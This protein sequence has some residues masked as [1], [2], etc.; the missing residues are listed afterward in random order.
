[1][2]RW[3]L[4]EAAAADSGSGDKNERS[5]TRTSGCPERAYSCFPPGPP[6]QLRSRPGSL[7]PAAARSRLSEPHSPQPRL[8]AQHGQMV[9]TRTLRTF[10]PGDLL[11]QLRY[12]IGDPG[13]TELRGGSVIRARTDWRYRSM[14]TICRPSYSASTVSFSLNLPIRGSNGYSQLRTSVKDWKAPLSRRIGV[15]VR[16][17]GP[18]WMRYRYPVPIFGRP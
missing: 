3:A 17:Q 10:L 2:P 18:R 7:V 14:P 4:S 8:D 5:S 9:D 16:E 6:W 1:M 15:L 11:V 12:S 13:H